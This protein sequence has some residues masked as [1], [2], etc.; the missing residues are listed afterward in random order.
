M[1]LGLVKQGAELMCI[2]FGVCFI[3]DVLS[4]HA[5]GYLCPILIFY[6]IFDALS[7]RE[8]GFDDKEAHSDI[9]N[10]IVDKQFKP[11]IGAKFVGITLVVVGG[12]LLVNNFLPTVLSYFNIVNYH[13]I[14]ELLRTG[15][16][17]LILVA[18]GLY[19]AFRKPKYIEIDKEGK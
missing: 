11:H 12:L 18:G 4:F 19:I 13:R 16:F 1:Y 6:S 17:A 14:M 7:K 15:A 10:W 9:I 8:T 5:I 2:F 3:A